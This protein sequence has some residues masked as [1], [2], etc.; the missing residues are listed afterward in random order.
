M[1]FPMA[2]QN[3]RQEFA[4]DIE[5]GSGQ[6]GDAGVPGDISGA[7]PT[8]WSP[9]TGNRAGPDDA[10]YSRNGKG[11]PA[12]GMLRN[13]SAESRVAGPRPEPM[14]VRREIPVV[15]VKD[16]GSPIGDGLANSV[17]GQ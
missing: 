3:I 11:S 7:L 12:V 2:V 17:V 6:E 14:F 5:A 15:F 13:D 10:G 16:H 4:H 1:L 9:N 8:W